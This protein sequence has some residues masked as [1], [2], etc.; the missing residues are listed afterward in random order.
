[1]IVHWCLSNIHII[2]KSATLHG[3]DV[4]FGGGLNELSCKCICGFTKYLAI[5]ALA[6]GR[7][8]HDELVVPV[9]S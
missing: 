6:G 5:T 4:H 2:V 1:M 7:S 8:T 9:K 3:E